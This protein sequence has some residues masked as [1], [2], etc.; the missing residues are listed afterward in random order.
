[1]K[2]SQGVVAILTA[3][4]VGGTAYSMMPSERCERADGGA[5]LDPA[6]SACR[7]GSG[8]SSGSGWHSSRSYFGSYGDGSSSSSGNA[9]S[10][11]ATPSAGTQRGGFGG[12]FSS[13]GSHI[14]AS[15]R[16]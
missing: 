3:A 2:R 12:F 8:G 14:A 13:L 1:M 10:G 5:P 16:A 11:S 6:S 15:A 4:M 7:S 9:P